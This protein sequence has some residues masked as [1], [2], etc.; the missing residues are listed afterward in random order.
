MRKEINQLKAGTLLTYLTM[1]VSSVIPM[2][3]TPLMLQLLGKDE[4]GL[5]S[6]SS[7]VT[8][9]L[10]LLNLG[11][12]STIL[13]YYMRYLTEGNKMMAER[14]MGLFSLLFGIIAV[15]TVAAGCIL[16]LFT[17]SLF[18]K[19]LSPAEVSK[20]NILIIILSIN[21]GFTLL[22][23]PL[24]TFVIGNERYIFQKVSALCFTL[25]A[26]ILN[27]IVLYMGHASIGLACVN[28]AVSCLV[29][30]VDFLYC[31]KKLHTRPRFKQMPFG[32]L[33]EIFSFTFVVFVS[34]IA[35]LLYWST[36]KVL[37][38]A[39]ISAAAVAVYNIG[40]TF[41]T[42]MQQMSSA[43]SGVFAPR[44]NR[45]IFSEQPISA[46]TELMTR[47]G[48]LQ[49]LIISLVLSGFIVFGKV[50]LGFWVGEG[51]EE[52]YPV[53]LLT[54]IPMVIPLIQN[55]AFTAIVAMN[56]HKF[57]SNLYLILA[58]ANVIA[59]FLVIP[60]L[61][62]V[63]AALCTFVVFILGHGIIMNWFYYKKININIFSFWKNIL[64]MSIV[65]TVL[66]AAGL[67]LH[68]FVWKMDTLLNFAIGVV[69]YTILFCGLSW[70]ISMN[71]YEKKLITDII[72][73]ILPKKKRAC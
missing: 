7:S 11:L 66:T 55:V 5:Y 30:L 52:A 8:H 63:G 64:K 60:Y 12:G 6:L 48:R 72:H 43:I 24:A 40:I 17:G 18:A 23:A 44:V 29:L 71:A 33:K 13:R 31:T 19:G 38:G 49:Y 67:L 34:I 57:R 4:Y 16:T 36:D 32:I 53:A 65:P 58:V 1:I 20:M 15:V 51:Y 2:L 50:F 35:E 28:V 47:V 41:N 42:I 22:A 25:A 37:I 56:K 70:L 26:P 9:Y 59:T 39:M 62:I 61:G 73:K 46:V 27:L 69:V 10:G 3:Y 45:L 68:H 14:V 21:S 54:M